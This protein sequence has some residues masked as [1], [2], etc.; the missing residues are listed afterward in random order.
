MYDQ[1]NA[2]QNG[3]YIYVTPY[4]EQITRMKRSTGGSRF[5]EP[6]NTGDGKLDAFHK[7]LADGEDI[8]T[9]H[10]LFLKATQET[11]QL[12][13]EGGYTLVLDEELGILQRYND[14]VS[15]LDNKTVNAADVQWLK[16]ENYITI[17]DC[18]VEWTGAT[19]DGFHYSEV[20]RLA[21][22]GCLRC[23][24][25]CLLW[26][27]PVDVFTAF[28]EAYILTYQFDG[29]LLSRYMDIYGLPYEKLSVKQ[30]AEKHYHLCAYRDDIEQR[31]ELSELVN[32][33]DGEL[34]EIGNRNNSLS[35]NWYESADKARFDEIK[36]TMRRY[37][38]QLGAP[39]SSI[40]WT[41]PKRNGV[42]DKLGISGFKY[43]RRLTKAE[44]RLPEDNKEKRMLRCFVACNARATND[45]RERTNCLY[46]LN[47][48]P[49][50]EFKTYFSKR[51]H[52]ID[53]DLFALSEMLQWIWRSAIRDR[54]RINLFI[55]SFRMRK[56]LCNWLGV[57]EV[58]PYKPRTELV[59][60]SP[61]LRQ[62]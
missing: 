12:I 10:A 22:S 35:V 13:S 41:A 37:R 16:Q 26:E 60:K 62:F 56:L 52:P 33:Y 11:V 5:K 24:N 32:I 7:L 43:V 39:S 23:V 28:K 25:D 47:R 3:S 59:L 2:D 31:K 55:P 40:M 51:G 38:D 48:F 46:L 18:C 53:D 29:S 45:F 42:S 49:L 17:T 9:T 54:R 44:R 30:D 15:N 27:F 4:L 6:L 8:A 61:S 19:V 20:E 36:K 1:I 50:L 14:V 57:E 21:R 58:P 34:N